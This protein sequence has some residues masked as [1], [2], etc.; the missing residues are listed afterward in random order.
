MKNIFILSVLGI[1]GAI[2]VKAA[3][4]FRLR[5]ILVHGDAY[6]TC[7]RVITNLE[8]ISTDQIQIT[9]ECVEERDFYDGV[10]YSHKVKAQLNV[11]ARNADP[12]VRYYFMSTLRY[13]DEAPCATAAQ[14]LGYSSLAPVFFSSVCKQA[15]DGAFEVQTVISLMD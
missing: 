6:L 12:N 9:G 3:D 1:L 8:A 4:S 5:E 10:P 13:P 15:A 2:N 11:L 14:R 7:E